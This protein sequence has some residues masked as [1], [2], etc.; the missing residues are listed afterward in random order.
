MN[1][2]LIADVEANAVSQVL[3]YL[4]T[5]GGTTWP[6]FDKNW[7]ES[8]FDLSE[9]DLEEAFAAAQRQDAD[10]TIGTGP[11]IRVIVRKDYFEADVFRGHVSLYGYCLYLT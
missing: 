10:Q 3:E 1:F 8:D 5:S 2:D 4:H 9:F 7:T 6:T 11:Y